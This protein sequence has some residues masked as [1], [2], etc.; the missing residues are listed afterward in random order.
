MAI[1]PG[2]L[3]SY[4]FYFRKI[5]ASYEYIQVSI[6]KRAPVGLYGPASETIF[7]LRFASGPTV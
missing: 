6:R 2:K 1:E 5:S 7:E 4:C 3:I